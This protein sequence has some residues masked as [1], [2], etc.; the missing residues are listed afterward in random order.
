MLASLRRGE[1]L[2]LTEHPT[3]GSDH[4]LLFEDGAWYEE[5]LN[6]RTDNCACVHHDRR[7][8]VR[9]ERDRTLELV[10]SAMAAAS[11]RRS[12]AAWLDAQVAWAQLSG[13]HA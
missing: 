9:V 11:A 10:R 12:E 5:R 1:P 8:R 3:L 13:G 2:V 7:E 4:A 6:C